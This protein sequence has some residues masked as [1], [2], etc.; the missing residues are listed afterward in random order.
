VSSV[1]NLSGQLGNLLGSDR[2]HTSDAVLQRYAIAGRAPMAVLKPRSSEEVAEIVSFAAA[3]KLTVIACGAR[4]KL[5]LGMP[6][7]R[8]DL[9]LDMT[10]LSQ[11]AHYDAGDLTVSVDAGMPLKDLA[12]E[13][14]V[15][16]QFLPLAV[17]FSATS[18]IAGAIASGIDSTLRMQYGTSRDFLIGAEFVDGTGK[19]CKSGGRVVKNVTG[20]D[21][22]KLLIGSLGTLGV[23]TRLNFRTYP[24]PELHGATIVTF[25]AMEAALTFHDSLQKSA[26]PFSN[27]ELFESQFAALLAEYSNQAGGGVRGL[28]R[29]D[30]WHVFASFAGI[31]GVMERIQHELRERC[32]QAQ[33]AHY[34]TLDEGCSQQWSDALRESFDWLRSAAANVTLLRI[35][36]PL[37]TPGDVTELHQALKQSTLRSAF[38][39]RACNVSYLALLS[40]SEDVQTNAAMEHCVS[41]VYSRAIAKNGSATLLHSPTWLKDRINVWGP[42][43]PD[44]PLMQRAKRAFDPHNIFAPGRFVGGL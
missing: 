35:V 17:P 30:V 43:R 31:A 11:I 13:L 18:T 10:G 41:D 16:K 12:M 44:Y 28:I 20:Y 4:T 7:Q 36:L 23:I 40:D 2:V 32:D 6:L 1:A 3:E 19:R 22:H 34:E 14:A 21:L 24:L 39:L 38:A 26:L 8:Y 27:L 25:P 29:E 9:A 42:K 37:W 5:E 33:A 15:K